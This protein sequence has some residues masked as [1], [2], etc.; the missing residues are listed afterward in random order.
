[1]SYYGSKKYIPSYNLN[2]PY[3]GPQKPIIVGQNDVVYSSYT[4]LPIGIGPVLQGRINDA[5]LGHP[6]YN[7]K[8]RVVE[9]NPVNQSWMAHG[10]FNS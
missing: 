7:K 9:F 2:I 8:W 1:M 3:G 6:K 4:G 10:Y 5:P